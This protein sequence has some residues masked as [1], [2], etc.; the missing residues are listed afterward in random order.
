MTTITPPS[1]KSKIIGIEVEAQK[2]QLAAEI[3]NTYVTELK[4]VLDEIGFSSASKNRKFIEQQL[5][6]TKKDLTKSEEHL[7]N[8]QTNNRIASL[9]DTVMTSIKSIGDL[10]GQKITTEAEIQSTN[11]AFGLFKA[12]VQSLQ[13]DPN[14]LTELDIK[15]KSLIAQRDALSHQREIFLKQLAELPPKGMALARLQRDVQVQNAIY[16]ALS[17]QYETAIISENKDS[18]AFI[19]LDKAVVPDKAIK[20]SKVKFAIAGLIFGFFIGIIVATM[21]DLGRLAPK[22]F[23]K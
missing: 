10:E 5:I 11:E 21:R 20:P 2:P 22:I 4:T 15:R 14:S 18:D 3:A 16:L 23:V 13:A 9:P 12:K 6:K 8:Y 1:L 19:V 17:Q 7:A